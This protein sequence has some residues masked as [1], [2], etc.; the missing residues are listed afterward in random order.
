MVAMSEKDVLKYVLTES[1]E[2]FVMIC[3]MWKMDKLSAVSLDTQ[4]HVSSY[5]CVCVCVCA[6]LL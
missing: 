6:T 3:L 5:S 4:M 1:L 2:L